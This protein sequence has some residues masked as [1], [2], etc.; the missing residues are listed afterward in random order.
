[1]LHSLNLS[2]VLHLSDVYFAGLSQQSSALVQGFPAGEKH[3]PFMVLS[4]GLWQQTRASSHFHA[5]HS[6]M[7][8][9]PISLCKW[10]LSQFDSAA[11]SLFLSRPAVLYTQSSYQRAL[12]L[13]RC[14]KTN[15]SSVPSCQTAS[16]NL[17]SLFFSLCDSCSFFFHFPFHLLLNNTIFFRA[18]MLFF[19]YLRVERS[20]GLHL[21]QE[22]G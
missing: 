5:F 8:A 4:Q 3:S 14:R 7:C 21:R 13:S 20:P 6:I 18:L 12:N 9:F 1:M 15:E 19:F 2:E 11:A 10:L 17:P 16:T 22:V